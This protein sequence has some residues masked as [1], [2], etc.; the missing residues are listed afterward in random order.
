M[1]KQGHLKFSYRE[2]TSDEHAL[3]QSLKNDVLFIPEY[4]AKPD[5]VIVDI[6]AHIGTFAVR[7]ASLLKN[8]KVYAVEASRENCAYLRANVKLNNLGNVSVHHLALT[9]FKGE[10]KLYHKGHKGHLGSSI[11]KDFLGEAENVPTDTLANFMQDNDISH[12]DYMKLNCEGAEFKIILSTHKNIL[13]RINLLLI[14]YHLDIAQKYSEQDLSGY[15]QQCGFLTKIRH[16]NKKMGRGM[17]I[18]ANNS[19]QPRLPQKAY[20]NIRTMCYLFLKKVITSRQI[21]EKY[22]AAKLLKKN[23]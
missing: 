10:T 6:G 16:R 4:A 17:I 2:G 23:G 15:L 5:H 21:L 7:A 3:T 13:Q 14:L 19:C 18:A 11:V 20:L 1:V 9:D 8:G 22:I 12:C